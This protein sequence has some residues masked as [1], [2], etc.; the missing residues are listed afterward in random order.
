MQLFLFFMHLLYNEDSRIV[1][2]AIENFWDIK[3]RKNNTFM[4]KF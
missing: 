3:D 4:L 1:A 2:N